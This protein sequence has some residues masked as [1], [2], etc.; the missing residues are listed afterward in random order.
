M[1]EVSLTEPKKSRREVLIDS[2][3]G[4]AGTFLATWLIMLVLPLADHDWT[5]GY[6]KVFWVLV[7]IKWVTESALW[8]TTRRMVRGTSQ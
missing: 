4:I 8:S 2:A 5:P 1:A 3:A 7:V 6:W